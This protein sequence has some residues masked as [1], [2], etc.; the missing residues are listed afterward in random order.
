MNSFDTVKLLEIEYRYER[1]VDEIQIEL[2][3]NMKL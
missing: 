3:S 1:A 2:E